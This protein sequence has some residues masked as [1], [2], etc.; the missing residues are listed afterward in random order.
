MI[1]KIYPSLKNNKFFNFI[2]KIISS[3]WS[4]I[5]ILLVTCLSNLFSLEIPMLY[6]FMLVVIL[7]SLFGD[8]MISCVPIFFCSYISF[9]RKN[10]PGSYEGGSIF[11]TSEGLIHMAITC[12][13]V[14]I[15]LL[16]RLIYELKHNKNQYKSPKLTLGFIFIAIA[17]IFG[18]IF[19]K[20]FSLNSVFVGFIQA[21][22]WI[23]VYFYFYYTVDFKNRS[24]DYCFKLLLGLGI[25]LSIEM[26]EMLSYAKF[27]SHPEAFDRS[28]LYT[29][30]GH[31]NNVGGML[32]VTIAVPFYYIYNSKKNNWI[33]LIIANLLGIVIILSQSRASILTALVIYIMCSIIIF[34]KIKGKEKGK[35]FLTQILSIVVLL[36]IYILNATTI[37][38]QFGSL[39]NAGFNP[40]GRLEIYKTGLK[41]FIESPIIGNSFIA[42]D[43]FQWGKPP[44]FWPARYHDTYVQLLASTGIIGMLSY[45]FHR[46]QTIKVLKNN[47]NLESAF[48]GIIILSIIGISILDCHFFNVGPAL[49]YSGVLLFMEKQK[50]V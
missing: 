14:F 24:K 2:N 32:A 26:L 45:I 28:K 1:I 36:N 44:A 16:I 33:W 4:M 8:D 42:C 17:F 20:Y 47:F 50:E 23:T 13:F 3:E 7:A 40:H 11:R 46:Y 15:F 41:Q 5:F 38:Q 12:S 21:V 22:S 31:N 35:L 39:I 6:T 34:I 48:L 43:T 29:G 30:W 10:N 49:I 18:G 37:N 27:W 9:S 25:V 19:T